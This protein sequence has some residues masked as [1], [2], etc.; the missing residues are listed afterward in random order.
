MKLIFNSLEIKG[1]G[2]Q[3]WVILSLE[4][5]LRLT[6]WIRGMN[7]VLLRLECLNFGDREVSYLSN[8]FN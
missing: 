2:F 5:W 6:R 7:L 8:G 1:L 4:Q 3:Q